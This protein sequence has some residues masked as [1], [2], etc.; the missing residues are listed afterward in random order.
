MKHHFLIPGPAGNLELKTNFPDDMIHAPMERLAIICHPHPLQGG[1]MDHKVVSTLS[2]TFL[3]LGCGII[4]FNYRGVNQ[5][6]GSFDNSLGETQDL[7]AVAEWAR[8]SIFYKKII[9]AGF[10]FGSF[11]AASASKVLEPEL[12]V[13]VAPSVLHS[14]FDPLV[15]LA[16]PWIVAMGTEDEV[17][18]VQAVQDWYDL[19]KKTKPELSELILFQDTGHFFHGQLISLHDNLK[20]HVQ[21][22]F[23]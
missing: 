1:T 8:A 19:R 17:V 22:Y 12:L 5:S 11:I 16:C 20:K 4:C 6:E 3:G 14:N 2:K 21:P 10:S 23:A 9:L 18:P 15:S 13:T 7:L